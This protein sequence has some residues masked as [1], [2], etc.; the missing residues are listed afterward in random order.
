M[1]GNL[2]RPGWAEQARLAAETLITQLVTDRKAL[3]DTSIDVAALQSE[4][5]RILDEHA[6]TLASLSVGALFDLLARTDGFNSTD[7]ATY[8]AAYAKAVDAL[9]AEELIAEAGATADESEALLATNEARRELLDDMAATVS[10]VVRGVVGAA[11]AAML[12]TLS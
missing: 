9:D 4:A 5:N 8:R 1:T 2:V 12:G 11:L 10:V 3:G 6:A 7:G